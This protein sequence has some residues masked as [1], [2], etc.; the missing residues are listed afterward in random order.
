MWF[1]R[2]GRSNQHVP[3]F[4]IDP[5][6]A[7]KLCLEKVKLHLGG[8]EEKEHRPGQETLGVGGLLRLGGLYGDANWTFG[9]PIQLLEDWCYALSTELQEVA[10]SLGRGGILPVPQISM[11]RGVGKVHASRQALSRRGTCPFEP[12]PSRLADLE[13][14]TAGGSVPPPAK[15]DCAIVI[16]TSSYRDL[17]PSLPGVKVWNMALPG[18]DLAR[19]GEGKKISGAVRILHAQCKTYW[20]GEENKKVK[21]IFLGTFGNSSLKGVKV[22]G[23]WGVAKEALNKTELVRRYQCVERELTQVVEEVGEECP[24]AD[25]VLVPALPRH[26]DSFGSLR[27]CFNHF[28]RLEGKLKSFAE[29]MD[30]E[31]ATFIDTLDPE[32]NI[33]GVKDI[34]AGDG[35]HPNSA[36]KE[37]LKNVI[38]GYWEGK[39]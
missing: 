35:V 2:R 31:V 17:A 12:T 7:K 10:D 15:L 1:D 11:V 33:N 25:I 13:P 38:E 28:K 36:G 23:K 27:E 14:V 21:A 6:R 24:G 29:D 37:F 20:G 32:I 22:D 3:T 18:L 30:L 39:K 4:V 16:G 8:G 9:V 34:L 5:E 19:E 26:P